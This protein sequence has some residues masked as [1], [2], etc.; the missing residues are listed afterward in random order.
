MGSKGLFDGEWVS[1]K[2]LLNQRFPVDD[3][4]CEIC[5]QA[6]CARSWISVKRRVVRC[7][8]C[9]TPTV[10]DEG[11]TGINAKRLVKGQRG[12]LTLSD[13]EDVQE[14]LERIQPFV[15]SLIDPKCRDRLTQQIHK[16]L[17]LSG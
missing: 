3:P 10:L 16:E 13:P 6:S 2:P 1:A 17:K 11:G 7:R 14:L 15:D 4:T 8:K 9:F 12:S 5:R